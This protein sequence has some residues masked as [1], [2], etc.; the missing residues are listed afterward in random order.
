MNENL[1]NFWSVQY[2]WMRTNFL[3]RER[4]DRTGQISEM[5]PKVRLGGL[6][7]WRSLPMGKKDKERPVKSDCRT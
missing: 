3:Q 5:N 6:H 2:N 1:M 4:L 7:R